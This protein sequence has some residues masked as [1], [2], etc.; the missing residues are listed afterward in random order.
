M[1]VLRSPTSGG[2]PSYYLP[3]AVHG[4]RAPAAR[5]N[6]AAINATQLV[7]SSTQVALTVTETEKPAP[8]RRGGWPQRSQKA[9][10]KDK[11]WGWC[12]DGNGWVAVRS[13]PG[14]CFRLRPSA[15]APSTI[16]GLLRNLRLHRERA[17]ETRIWPSQACQ[18][19]HR[20]GRAGAGR[21]A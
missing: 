20:A 2:S 13:A 14:P 3:N 18:D 1:T 11:S 4:T 15:Q 19:R 17:G 5:S 21:A 9:A 12:G 10:D 6:V 16:C 7:P 8:G